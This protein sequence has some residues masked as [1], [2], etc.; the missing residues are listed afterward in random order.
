MKTTREI[1]A[2]LTLAF[3]FCSAVTLW[4]ETPPI[5]LTLKGAITLAFERNLD[6]KVELYNP[7]L[8]EA[9]IRRSLGIYDPLL[10]AGAG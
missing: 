4:A 5:N 1:T 3:V 2:G 9:D 10:S 7:A 8:A 6:L